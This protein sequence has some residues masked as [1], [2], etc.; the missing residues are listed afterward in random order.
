MNNLNRIWRLQ[1]LLAKDSVQIHFVKKWYNFLHLIK[2]SAVLI[3]K[4]FFVKNVVLIGMKDK[5]AKILK[6][7]LSLA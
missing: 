1:L 3:A 4:P 7:L 2:K 6:H 5:A